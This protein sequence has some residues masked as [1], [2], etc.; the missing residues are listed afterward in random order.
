M[1]RSP[2]SSPGAYRRRNLSQD[3]H[4]DPEEEDEDDYGYHDNHHDDMDETDFTTL[5]G[6]PKKKYEASPKYRKKGS[7]WK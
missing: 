3:R 2:H 7:S 6:S 1:P 5:H 4:K